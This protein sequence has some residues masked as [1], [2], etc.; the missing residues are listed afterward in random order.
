M[1]R[2]NLLRLLEW[3]NTPPLVFARVNSLRGDANKL[4]EQWAREKV[5]SLYLFMLRELRR[6]SP[7]THNFPPP[8]A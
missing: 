6:S 4:R 3:N 8:R 5:E 1:G 2:D 7:P